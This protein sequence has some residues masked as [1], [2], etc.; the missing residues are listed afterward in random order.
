[1]ELALLWFGLGDMA[2]K[3]LCLG[4]RQPFCRYLETADP[5]GP[6]SA[7]LRPSVVDAG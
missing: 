1:M 2:V 7:G 3:A 6:E 4:G 5:G